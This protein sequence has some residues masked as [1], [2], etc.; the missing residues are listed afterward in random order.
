MKL[1]QVAASLNVEN[2]KNLSGLPLYRH[3]RQHFFQQFRRKSQ[4]SFQSPSVIPSTHR[5]RNLS[6]IESE[7]SV[8]Q[9]SDYTP[10]TL[11]T[12]FNSLF[13]TLGNIAPQT[14]FFNSGMAAI[15]SLAY[16]LH[17]S[18]NIQKL[19]LGENA[20][21]ETKWLLGDYHHCQF[22]NEYDSKIPGGHDVYWFEFPLNCTSP[23]KYPF[24]Q[25]L[26]LRDFFTQFL[27]IVPQSDQPIFL[28]LDY[29]LATI[30]LDLT[31]YLK[32]LPSNLSI[33]LVTSLQKHRGCGLDLTNA[34]AITFYSS[35]PSDDYENLSRI[36]A[37]TGSSITQETS[38]LMPPL[39][40]KI[41]NQ[42]ILDSGR[43][44]VK[45][46]HAINRPKLPIKFH[47]AENSTFQTSFIF[48][49]IDSELLKKSTAIPYFSD[50]LMAEFVASAKRH[51]AV[52]IQG[53]SFGFPFCRVFKNSERYANTSTLRLAVGYDPDF[54]QHLDEAII[55]G[56][57]RF[58]IKHQ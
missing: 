23:K 57:D 56:V 12:S 6:Q 52:L 10:L 33:Y 38:W 3:L 17:G 22:I 54:N 14:L 37:I 1:A 36:R 7:H 19:L 46:F 41:I 31:P 55:E 49:E 34:G 25:Q 45:L 13:P 28:V 48:V 44:T 42:I 35:S 50:L 24:T 20:Y 9:R 29:T 53:T 11:E 4:A 2:P 32:T 27:N 5:Q 40:P 51:H 47:C 30:P 26:D 8:Y 21:F 15:S 43:E 58:L 16:Y 18:K 39:N